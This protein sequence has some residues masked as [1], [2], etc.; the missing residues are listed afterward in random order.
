MATARCHSGIWLKCSTIQNK[1]CASV[2]CVF[3]REKVSG[4]GVRYN[5]ARTTRV[6]LS[7]D[8]KWREPRVLHRQHEQGLLMDV[9]VPEIFG[10]TLFCSQCWATGGVLIKKLLWSVVIWDC[11][12]WHGNKAK[13]LGTFSIWDGT[14]ERHYAFIL[15]AWT[16]VGTECVH[17]HIQQCSS[18]HACVQQS[19][20]GGGMQILEWISAL[21]CHQLGKPWPTQA[22][23][24]KRSLWMPE[25]PLKAP[26]SPPFT[27]PYPAFIKCPKRKNA[28]LKSAAYRP[29][30]FASFGRNFDCA[31]DRSSQLLGGS[32]ASFIFS[33][34]FLLLPSGPSET[35]CTCIFRKRPFRSWA[36][37]M[38]HRNPPASLCLQDIWGLRWPL[39]H[40]PSQRPPSLWKL[41]S[42]SGTC[43]FPSRLIPQ[44]C[45]PPNEFF[46]EPSVRYRFRHNSSFSTVRL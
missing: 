46:W 15:K 42:V 34:N 31:L 32:G 4:E 2:L 7:A 44:L 45:V 37:S 33:F 35:D 21:T 41:P 1:E 26:H 8:R 3:V 22:L 16:P 12:W 28:S 25:F 6:A 14:S 39:L 19:S 36:I 30:I 27:S 23:L 29:P 5:G 17:L 24:K 9:D 11:S 18:R 40:H 10:H 43:H 38:P 20:T 13:S